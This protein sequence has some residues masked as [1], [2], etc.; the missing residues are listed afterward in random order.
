MKYLAVLAAIVL[1]ACSSSTQ[2]GSTANIT[3]PDLQIEQTFGPGEL[4]YPDA[5]IDVK[6]ELHIANHA[7][8]PITLKR[9]NLHTVNPPGG[10]YTLTPPLVHAFNVEIPASGEKVITMWA[11]ARSYGVSM[12]DREPVTVKGIAYFDTAQGYYN[13]QVNQE[14]QQ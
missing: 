14:L 8:I 12:R 5:P 11:H 4:G 10:A 9:I 6:Y 13:L 1:A 3:A 2:M 7:S